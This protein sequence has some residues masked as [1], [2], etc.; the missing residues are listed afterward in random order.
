MNRVNPRAA[1]SDLEL[2]RQQ[3][4]VREMARLA[5]ERLVA[6]KPIRLDLAPL[7]GEVDETGITASMRR[8]M[9]GWRD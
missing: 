7:H 2:A 1:L 4:Q 3:H 5:S 6:P 8:L 9:E